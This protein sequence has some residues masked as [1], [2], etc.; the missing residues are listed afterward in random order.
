MSR[1]ALSVSL[2]V[3]LAVVAAL[4]SIPFLARERAPALGATEPIAFNQNIGTIRGLG[5][6]EWVEP[7]T[8]RIRLDL[9]GAGDR[10]TP[11]LSLNMPDHAMEPVR[12]PV[13]R[14]P[15]GRFEAVA[16]LLMSGYWLLRI[17]V[18]EGWTDVGFRLPDYPP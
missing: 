1:L 6:I 16:T 18:P 15:D 8:V 11:R 13:E 5:D 9:G 14:L 17:E 2:V 4:A 3:L 7:G 12:P 10:M